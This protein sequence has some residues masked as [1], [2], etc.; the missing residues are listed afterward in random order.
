M[1]NTILVNKV[2]ESGI[3]TINLEEFFP[4]HE[5]AVFDIKEYLYLGLILKEKE[6]REALKN[7]SLTLFSDKIVLVICSADAII[8]LWAYMLINNCLTGV[9]YD[10]Y[11]GTEEEYLKVHY[12]EVLQRT[13]Y[14]QYQ[15]QRIVIK[16]CSNKPVPSYAYAYLTSLLRPFAQS[17]MFGEPCSTVPIFKRP[18]TF[19]S[20]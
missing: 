17:I 1:E 20:H 13:D 2:A 14:K 8:P 16:G 9:A 7:L 10:I 3:I 15:D 12:R 5:F 11:T 19:Q 18:R 4:K 6:F